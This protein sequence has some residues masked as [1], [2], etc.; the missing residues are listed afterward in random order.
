[1]FRGSE[2]GSADAVR[3]IASTMTRVVTDSAQLFSEGAGCA[4]LLT[5]SK[6]PLS[7]VRGIIFRAN[8]QYSR[9]RAFFVFRGEEQMSRH[10][11]T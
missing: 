9:S 5:A 7:Y 11:R 4:A 1:M 8:T 6:V 10:S 3:N 2:T